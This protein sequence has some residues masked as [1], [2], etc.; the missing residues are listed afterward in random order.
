MK[1]SA[2][3]GENS[4]GA[5]FCKHCGAQQS[6]PVAD[7]PGPGSKVCPSCGKPNKAGA[8]FC[9]SCSA[10]LTAAEPTL[11][12]QAPIADSSETCPK[13]GAGNKSGV[14]FCVACGHDLRK[15]AEATQ[16]EPVFPQVHIQAKDVVPR[17]DDLGNASAT[18]VAEVKSDTK[19]PVVVDEADALLNPGHEQKQ[20]ATQLLMW[21]LGAIVVGA[22][23]AGAYLYLGK[24]STPS[25]TEASV[26]ATAPAASPAPAQA[27]EPIAVPVTPAQSTSLP[28]PPEPVAGNAPVAPKP[29]ATTTEGV[30][31][32][33]PVAKHA[34]PEKQPL[35][36]A[37]KP[38]STTK[39]NPQPTPSDPSKSQT[40]QSVAKPDKPSYESE[41]DAC[42]KKGFFER[43][44]CT[45]QV[46]WKYCTVNG[47]WD[48]SKPGCE[49]PSNF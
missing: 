5:R 15:R 25:P 22:L 7:Q 3:G 43:G 36:P 21:V 27:P 32:S 10:S 1:C 11:V 49:R 8:K 39:P 13:C 20:S 34:T 26:P 31:K 18:I 35:V 41:L 23:A 28:V 37:S 9:T 19:E 33:Q 24:R 2:C 42:R 38:P 29:A 16:A 12:S 45:E 17:E 14:G 46:K 44:I 47:V 4:V 6:A 30:K 48:N 40:E